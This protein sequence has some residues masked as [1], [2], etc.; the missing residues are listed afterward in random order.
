[1]NGLREQRGI[2][3]HLQGAWRKEAPKRETAYGLAYATMLCVSDDEV[4]KWAEQVMLA[5][6]PNKK[7]Q[8]INAAIRRLGDM[9]H[10]MHSQR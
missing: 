5:E 3:Q 2:L 9:V 4:R 7:L 8:A 1:M 10:E 6:D